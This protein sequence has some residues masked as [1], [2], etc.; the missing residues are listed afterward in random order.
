MALTFLPG[1]WTIRSP[2]VVDGRWE[3]DVSMDDGRY[4]LGGH[5]LNRCGSFLACLA[6]V[7][8]M[9]CAG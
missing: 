9:G 6:K 8:K 5:T 1:K 4:G 3:I 2:C 7:I